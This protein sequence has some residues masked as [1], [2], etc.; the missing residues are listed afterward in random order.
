MLRVLTIRLFLAVAICVFWSPNPRG[1]TANTASGRAGHGQS[2]VHRDDP[3]DQLPDPPGKALG[4]D[5]KCPQ[6]GSSSGVAKGDFNGDG[7]ADL[8]IGEPGA[9]IGGHANA[10]DVI[11]IY[12]SGSGL[13]TTAHRADI[14]FGDLWPSRVGGARTVDSQAGD[15]FGSALASGDFNG[16]GFSDLA[17]G[18]PGKDAE[19]TTGGCAFGCTY[20]NVGQVVLLYGSA[21]GLF[22]R[23]GQAFD[24][25]LNDHFYLRD[26]HVAAGAK[27]GQSLAWGDF[28]GD[29]AGDLA[30][31]A[32]NYKLDA[33]LFAAN[34]EAGA[35]WILMGTKKTSTSFGGLT[36]Q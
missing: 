26:G 19:M 18:I 5:K 21:N 32:P 14:W 35:V 34:Q 36:T 13:S 31:G 33:G 1:Q 6:G 4:I 20:E 15:L 8:A 11:V 28:N 9:T 27:L 12:G 16:D 2:G 7:F 23:T 29:G 24:F 3:C 25:T 22:V 17:I 30:I 10:G